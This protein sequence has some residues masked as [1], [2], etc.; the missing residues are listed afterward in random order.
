M[1]GH[2]DALIG[3][4]KEAEANHILGSDPFAVEDLTRRMKYGDYGRAERDRDVRHRH[5]R[6]GLLGH[7]G[8]GAGGARL[9]APRG[10]GHRQG[11][12]LRQRLVHHRAD[13][14]GLPQGRPGV[15]ERG[16]KALKIDPFGTG[17]F[18]L[19]HQQTLYAVSLIEAVRDAIGPDAELM[20]EMHGRFSPP[21]PYGWPTSWRP[22]SPRGWRSPARR[23]TSRPWRRSPRRSTSRWPPVSASTTASSSASCSRA[24][25]STSSS[26]TS[27]TSAESGRRASWPRP[28]RRTTCSSPRTTSA[29][30]C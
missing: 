20:L 22:S 17:H 11:E 16:Y 2:T 29:G 30:R 1:L 5:R 23:R 7:Q 27:V 4:L 9:A 18:E 3:Y 28:P 25:P 13:P 8:Q 12:G 6:D 14:G 21:P 26:P 19:D 10:Q 24:R 15:M